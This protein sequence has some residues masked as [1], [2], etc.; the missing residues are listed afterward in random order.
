VAAE[1]IPYWLL[2]S[3]LFSTVPLTPAL[4]TRLHRAALDLYRRDEG[5]TRLQGD[6]V[7][8]EVRN[9]KQ[10]LLLGSLG[11]PGFEAHLDTERGAGVV[12]FL[13]TRQGIELMAEAETP[14]SARN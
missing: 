6:L 12:R 9:L 13:L 3:V 2:I 1:S 14:P 11:G 10:D 4:A 5:V 8:G 7:Q